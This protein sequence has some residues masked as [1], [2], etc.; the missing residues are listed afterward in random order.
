MFVRLGNYCKSIVIWGWASRC[1]SHYMYINR[2]LRKC[3][4]TYDTAC[5]LKLVKIKCNIV[6]RTHKSSGKTIEK[7]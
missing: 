3:Q 7:T 5:I 2:S 1:N 4:S 6:S